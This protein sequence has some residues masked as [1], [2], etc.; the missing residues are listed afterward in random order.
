VQVPVLIGVTIVPD[1]VH[2]V[3]VV[4][5]KFTARPEL[6]VALTVNAPAL[7]ALGEAG[8]VKLMVWLAF[9]TVKLRLTGVAAAQFVLPAWVAWRLQVP[10]VSS[11]TELPDTVHT[12]GV[13]EA[14]FTAKLELAV[15]LTVNGTVVKVRFEIVPK[16]MVWVPWVTEKLRL[17]DAAAAQ[18]VLPAWLAVIV[19][20]PTAIGVTVVPV[21]VH[22]PVVDA[23]KLTVSP[24]LEVAFTMKA[25]ALRARL[26]RAAKVMV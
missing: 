17:T 15:A 21:T 16:V 26:P 24:E 3:V 20:V 4:E 25:P 8:W 6:A 18:L 12:V 7:T 9:D 5:A 13:V 22:T 10:A 19:Q 11:V 2:T 1:T 23:V 14:R